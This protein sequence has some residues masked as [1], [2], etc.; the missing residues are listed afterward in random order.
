FG[1]DYN[2][3]PNNLH[4][5][6]VQ[7][8]LFFTTNADNLE[9][10]GNFYLRSA[11]QIQSTDSAWGQGEDDTLHVG[12]AP[13]NWDEDLRTQFDSAAIVGIENLIFTNND[14]TGLTGNGVEMDGIGIGDEF[15]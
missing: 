3:N 8:S 10:E 1:Q 14:F 2:T 12:F 9:G 11:D 6:V 13:T 7:N 5:I 15:F 4:S